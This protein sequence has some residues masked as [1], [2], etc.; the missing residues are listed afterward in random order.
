MVYVYLDIF[1]ENHLAVLKSTMESLFLLIVELNLFM[2]IGV[3]SVLLLSFP[4]MSVIY[5]TLFLFSHFFHF[6]L[7]INSIN[8]LFFPSSHC[9]FIGSALSFHEWLSFYPLQTCLNLFH[10]PPIPFYLIPQIIV[11]CL[12]S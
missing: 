1:R 10:F 2:S 12:L 6:F 4:L 9:L 3:N 7:F 8:C 5:F 11:E